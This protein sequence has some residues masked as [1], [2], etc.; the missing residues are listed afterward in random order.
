MQFLSDGHIDVNANTDF[1][2]GIDVTGNITVTGTVD[3]VDI[4]ARN[5]LFGGLTSSSGVLTNGVTATTQSAS[6][7]STKVATTAYTDT[8]IANLVDS[9]PSTLDTLNE[10]AAALGDD[11][12]FATT[13]T[14]SIATKLPLAGGTLTGDLTISN[15]APSIALIDTDSNSDFSIFGSQGEFRIRDQ[16]NTTNRLTIA[17]DGTTT[18]A[19]NTDFG[20]GIDVTGN[21]TVTG[22]V[23]GRDIA[24]DGTKLDGIE[25]SATADQ[26]ASEIVALVADQTIAP[27]TIDMEDNEKILLGTGDDLELWTDGSDSYVQ[28]SAS[29]P[30]NLYIRNLNSGKNIIIDAKVGERSIWCKPDAAVEL[31]YDNSKKLETSNDGIDIDNV[32]KLHASAVNQAESGRIRFA[33]VQS[34][35]QGA[36]IHYD[37]NANELHIG[38]HESNTT[39][40]ADDFNALTFSRSNGFAQFHADVTFTGATSGYNAV[41][42]KSDNALEF[43]DN[44]KATFGDSGDLMIYHHPTNGSII[45]H[46]G[47]GDLVIRSGNR[48]DLRSANDDT[49]F[50]RFV[51]DGAA[52]LY[53]DGSK[54]FET[55]SSGI[56][57][58]GAALVGGNIEINQ[59]AYL[60]IGAG[61]DLNFTHTGTDSY[62]Q[63]VTGDL[64]I[65]NI[66]TNSDDIFIAAKDDINIRVQ[67][68][69]DAIKCI[70]DGAVELYYDNSKKLETSSDGVIFTGA[71]RFVGNETGF[72]TGKAQ[73][74][75]YRTASTSG[76]YPFNEFGHLVIQ[77]RND[78][79]NRDI[80]FATGTSSAKLNRITSDGHLDLLGDNQKL[81]IGASQD[82]QLWHDG[83][84]NIQ[85]NAGSL[86]LRS[87][88]ASI[89][90][91]AVNVENSIVCSPNA[92]VHLYYDNSKKFETTSYGAQFTDNVKFD[93]PDTAGRDLT[94]E[95]D[96]DSLHWEDNTKATFGAGNDLQIYHDGSNSYIKDIGT[97]QLRL[98]TNEFLITNA[99]VSEN[100]FKIFENG[101][102]ELYYDASK[103]LE[104]TSTGVS[105]TGNIAVSGTV[106]GVDVAAL[107]ASVSG[108]LSNIV[109]D[110]SPQLGGELQTN[111]NDISF[112]DNDRA[113]F[114]DGDDFRIFHNGSDNFISG[115]GNI[116]L[117]SSGFLDI[118]SDGNETMIKATPNGAV[119]LYHDGSLKAN[120]RSDGFEIKQHLTMGDSDE[121]RLG[122]SSDLK[123]YHDGSNSYIQ[124]L[125][126]GQLRFL[127]ND[128]V[129]YNAGGNE[130]I[131][132]FI[133]NGAV[134]L[135][136]NGSKKA[137]TYAD[138]LHIDTGV[139]R[140]DDNALIKLGND[141]DLQIYHDSSTN[142]GFIKE[143]GTGRLQIWTSSL[144]L[145]N[146]AGDEIN[147]VTNE[148]GN[149]ELWFDNSKKFETTSTG[150][151]VTGTLAATNTNIT[152]QMFMP[153]NGQI[154]LGDSDDLQ[155][156]HDGSNSYIQNS[157]GGLF[158]KNT[159]GSNLD[160]FSHG[161]A[162]IR[163]NAGE[164]AV[165]CSHNSSVDLY[166]DNSKKLGTASDGIT[167]Y[168]RIAADELDMGDSEKIKLGTGDDLQIYHD[169]SHSYIKNTTGHLRIGDANVV[170]MNAACNENMIHAVQNDRVELYYDNSVKFETTSTGINIPASVPTITLSDTDGN[171]PYS[172]ITAGGG[173]LVFEADQGDE[174]ANTLMLFRV[175]DSEAMRIESSGA[176]RFGATAA[177]QQEK[178]TFFR[179]ESD[180][181]TLAYFHQGASA[182]VSGIWMRH[183][184]A[185]SGFS[186]KMISFRRNDG[187]EVGSITLGASSTSFNTSSDYR[188]KENVTSITDGITRLKTLKP[189]RFNFKDDTTKPVV[190]GFFAHEVTAVP[191]AITGT[192]DEV[193]ADN[194]PVYQSI[195]HSKLV[196]LLVAAVQELIGRVE[197]LEGA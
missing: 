99:A 5:T 195:D 85:A 34:T 52:E 24:T 169:G 39:N 113:T 187:N 174:E 68:T 82:F 97:G 191:E 30:N 112:A 69:E 66:G 139:L 181:N 18:I 155:I 76:S 103:K 94:W 86:Y 80:I 59:D 157:T 21:I 158:I 2:A 14:N 60:K 31:Y 57:V 111:G 117:K 143:L 165:D 152:T 16:T 162:R 164:M 7:N 45:N 47:T 179:Q 70:G 144:H 73:P 91:R 170:I 101:A 88:S 136:F 153:D 193:D 28:N 156:Y 3:G 84:N 54:K 77:S 196:P 87:N 146:Q 67:S 106:D 160:V 161:S 166:F 122:N 38:T 15:T 71:A 40:S 167:V 173:D 12:N 6:D 105:V 100:M 4:A 127:S 11:P 130:N 123:I 42:D 78:G 55:S 137:F 37:G 48:I 128:Y 8:A 188:L 102:V 108:F 190:D 114:G 62:I 180:A 25:A 20:A 27:S 192:K 118:R 189:Y 134:E 58:N 41:W 75:I 50:A 110:T 131:A 183:G 29:S 44:A 148:N 19:G 145:K 9:A 138:G 135:Y 132:R 184:R 64:Y 104:T 43:A 120:T 22:T 140:G 142:D 176:I 90:L 53:Y 56:T 125:G 98:A 107:S 10:L 168:G 147:L 96:N 26:T 49:Y 149:C 151:T 150:A 129:F 119:E 194:N 93:N 186:G 175:D 197:K 182:D 95:A 79:S 51:E 141:G 172:R 65:Q 46:F 133:E 178:Y 23:D 81:R 115:T 36:F 33:E 92:A 177:I 126:T 185:L 32:I 63:N 74:T 89:Y 17:S 171:T 83:N 1:A 159:D 109:E 116:Y 35:M 13:V 61:N 163:V 154:R 72:L 121:I 124:D